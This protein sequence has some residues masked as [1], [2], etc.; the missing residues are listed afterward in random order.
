MNS[1]ALSICTPCRSNSCARP[2]K[3]TPCVPAKTHWVQSGTQQEWQHLRNWQPYTVWSGTHWNL[4]VPPAVVGYFQVIAGHMPAIPVVMNRAMELCNVV[5][6]LYDLTLWV[7]ASHL[8]VG[9]I[10]HQMKGTKCSS[11]MMV[12]GTSTRWDLWSN[13]AL[14][15][16]I[17]ISTLLLA[18]SFCFAICDSYHNSIQWF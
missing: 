16:S 15:C 8:F 14:P 6:P 17:D 18:F 2:N 3:K 10:S 4:A 1:F 7:V 5:L 12:S 11:S 13:S 9:A